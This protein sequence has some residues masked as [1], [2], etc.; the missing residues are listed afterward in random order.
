MDT[1][2]LTGTRNVPAA[3]IPAWAQALVWQTVKN[4]DGTETTTV[5]FKK[6]LRAAKMAYNKIR[7][8]KEYGFKTV[9]TLA[10]THGTFAW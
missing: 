10:R 1:I 9:E 2:T 6:T 8:G 7:E 3:K 4:E 5:T